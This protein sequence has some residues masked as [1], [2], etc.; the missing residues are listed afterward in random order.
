MDD[1]RPLHE[2]VRSL[3]S[4]LGQVIRTLEGEEAFQ[5]VERL[6][7]LCKARRQQ[8]DD[9]LAAIREEVD[10][11]SNDLASLVARS[12]TLFFLLINTAEQVHRVRRRR[13]YPDD[14]PPAGSPRWALAKLAASGLSAEQV[15]SRL[16]ALRVQPVLTA[17]PTESTRR[18]VLGLQ[19]R[20][21]DALLE[22]S[23]AGGRARAR[24]SRRIAAEVELLWLTAE[25]R[26][27]RPSVLDEVSTVAWYLEDR[28]IEAAAAVSSGWERAFEEIYG[29]GLEQ[30]LMLLEPGSWVG[31]DRDGNPFVTPEVT[32]ASTRRTAH[33]LLRVY[34][35]QVDQL[36]AM[37]SI[38]ERISQAP[39][40]LRASLEHDR[41][42]LPE[43][44]EAN[45][46]R[47]ADEP[48]RL[49]LTFI[50]ERIRATRARIGWFDAGHRGSSPHDQ[51]AYGSP[52]AL[53]ADLQLVAGAVEGTGARHVLQDLVRPLI[54]RV[55][56]HG[57]HGLALDLREDAGVHT[58]AL[59]EV[60][61]ALG[62]Q[63]MDE[64][65]LTAELLGRR[66][67]LSPHMEL[68]EPTR[69][70]VSVFSAMSQVQREL[71][72]RAAQTYIISMASC[73]AD[74]LRVLLLG[75]EAGL[76]ALAD[77]RSSI[78][79]VPLF[80]TQTDLLAA[81]KVLDAL[82]NNPA[83]AAQLEAR[84]R[85]Q[86]VMLGYSDSAKD[87]GI[88]P[89]AWSLYTA[90]EALHATAK[91]HKI[92]LTLFH[93]RGGTVGRGGGSP[94]LRALSALPPNTVGSRVKITEQGETISQKFGLAPLAE[95]SLEVMVAGTA[96]A[97][98]NDW[99]KGL[100]PGTEDRYRAVMEEL[101]ALAH[102]VFRTLVHD[103]PALFRLFK[104]ITP[105]AELGK[106]HY[107]SRPAYRARGAGTMAGI[108]A[109]PWIFGWT[110][111]RLMLPGWLGVGTALKAVAD[112]PGGLQTLSEMASNWPFFDDLLGKVEMVAAKADLQ[113]ARMYLTQLGGEEALF[114]RLEAEY[115]RVV[116][117]LLAIRGHAQLLDD[118]PVLQ[119]SIR[120][121][122]P[123]VDALSVLQVTGLLRRRG[124]GAEQEALSALLGSVTNGIAQGMRNTG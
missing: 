75:R 112:R 104:T 88:L 99:R 60:S 106:V 94:V 9:E 31:G 21:A 27:D 38:S 25:V 80:E 43:A 18:T 16:G 93:G 81:P 29:I 32:L 118:N 20:I 69:R 87:A 63:P 102:P 121:R 76:V 49:K 34:R 17:H 23:G 39:A 57:L 1:L 8:G 26:S 90:Q 5:A 70:T 12:F 64:G 10:A 115:Q 24:L 42:L 36:V 85:H 46:R 14:P 35:D 108:R 48:L 40:A 110:Q 68:S 117:V 89:A 77:G 58:E 2:D 107:G 82:A 65:A 97:G 113:I 109:I 101:S 95:R 74:L 114:G 79:V 61:A 83:Y 13:S 11:W 100:P 96:L 3:A 78:D 62:L 92:A 30:P 59:D 72:T 28:L 33:R 37:L 15:E 47:D 111:I 50:R 86:E 116:E 45:R 98:L 51:A 56:R 122:N 44:W 91:R 7:A 84:G 6:R 19:A 71:G 103:D 119:A 53:L 124:D 22:R 66:P 123:Y 41:A 4:T 55:Q 52:E 54:G 67:L 105:V 73:P 120:L